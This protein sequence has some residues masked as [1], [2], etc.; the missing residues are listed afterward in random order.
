MIRSLLIVKNLV[1]FFDVK[2][3]QGHLVLPVRL[4]QGQGRAQLFVHDANN[5][6]I[7]RSGVDA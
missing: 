4:D 1:A 2:K 5:F 6:A 7:I 3:I